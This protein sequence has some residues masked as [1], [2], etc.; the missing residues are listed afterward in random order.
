[1]IGTHSTTY[2]LKALGYRAILL[3]RWKRSYTNLSLKEETRQANDILF[4]A[5]TVFPFVLF[6]DSITIDRLKVTVTHRFFFATAKVTGLQIDDILNVEATVGPFFGSIKIWTP[7]FNDR[8]MEAGKPIE[9]NF[10]SRQDA[11]EV[12]TLLQGYII[13]RNKKIE[14]GTTDKKELL[15]RLHQL[16]RESV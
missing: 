6:P 10:L 3:A 2:Q 11:L 1:M 15:K 14:T 5:T 13:A 4:R 7:V 8:T 12:E 9:V 16:G